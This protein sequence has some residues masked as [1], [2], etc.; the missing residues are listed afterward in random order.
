M[1]KT[2]LLLFLIFPFTLAAQEKIDN[3]PPTTEKEILWCDG[4]AETVS[5]SEFAGAAPEAVYTMVEEMPTFVG[6]EEA[7]LKFIKKTF[8]YPIFALENSV[9]GSILL[10]FVITKTGCIYKPRVISGIGSGCDEEALR[11]VQQ[12]PR[13][14]PG[15]ND[16]VPVAV[17][18]KMTVN[19][20]MNP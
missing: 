7:R 19:I 3:A 17:Q 20:N 5:P 11:V 9:Q 18:Y 8:K 14:N 10:T 12:M 2:T 13:W 1:K 6:G 15:R 4:V 16:G